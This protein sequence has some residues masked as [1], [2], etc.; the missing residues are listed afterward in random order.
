M[1]PP[2]LYESTQYL[3]SY[4]DLYWY[5]RVLRKKTV[6]RTNQNNLVFNFVHNICADFIRLLV[7]YY[8]AALYA[9]VQ[10]YLKLTKLRDWALVLVPKV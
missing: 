1:S 10:K 7:E 9:L 4:S 3:P 8:L 6:L 5:S 2:S